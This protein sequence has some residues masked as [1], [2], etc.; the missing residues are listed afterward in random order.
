MLERVRRLRGAAA[1]SWSS[2]EPWLGLVSLNRGIL[3]L[4]H[5]KPPP[6]LP[7]SSY[8]RV[9]HLELTD[10][11]LLRRAALRS[12]SR[13]RGDNLKGLSHEIEMGLNSH[14]WIV[15][16]LFVGRI[17]VLYLFF[18]CTC[19]N[20]KNCRPACLQNT[21][22]LTMCQLRI[23]AKFASSQL[24]ARWQ[25]FIQ[26]AAS[27][28]QISFSQSPA[29]CKFHS[30]S[31]SVADPNPNPRGSELFQPEPNPNPKFLFLIRI[32]IRIR[33]RIQ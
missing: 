4:L 27:Q 5:S 22:R 8:S 15:L 13:S 19:F 9:D 18:V 7:A 2:S 11:D 16:C 30:V 12:R 23:F 28:M 20:F 33:F 10:T 24:L 26:S 32:R 14:D 6:Q 17:L 21:S 25:N 31:R 29:G 1:A 3:L